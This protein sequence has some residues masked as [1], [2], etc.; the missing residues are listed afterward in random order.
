MRS[1]GGG[2]GGRRGG[3]GGGRRIGSDWSASPSSP[4]RVDGRELSEA[5]RRRSPQAS[6]STIA[7]KRRPAITAPCTR[8]MRHDDGGGWCRLCGFET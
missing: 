8:V 3:D 1:G 4:S 7:P 6:S 2:G 5:A